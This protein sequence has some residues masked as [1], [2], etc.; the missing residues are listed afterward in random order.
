MH[1][2]TKSQIQAAF[3]LHGLRGTRQRR[4]VYEAM[5][6]TT[7]HPTADQLFCQLR[8]HE[9]GMS[10]ATVY[11]TLEAFCRVGL[12]TKL[13]GNGTSAHYDATVHNHLHTRCERSDTVRDVPNTLSQKLLG[14]IPKPVLEQIESEMGFKINQVQIALV[15]EYEDSRAV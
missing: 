5:L 14:H 2:A 8:Q 12:A 7:S 1:R 9:T 15:G 11:N 4:A 3:S 6:A 13:P 10:L